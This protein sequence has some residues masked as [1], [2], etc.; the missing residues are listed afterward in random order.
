MHARTVLLSSVGPL[1]ANLYRLQTGQFSDVEEARA[2]I[3][4]LQP[5]VGDASGTE[6]EDLKVVR[7]LIDQGQLDMAR[8]ALRF[9]VSGLQKGRDIE[10]CRLLEVVVGPE[11]TIQILRQPPPGLPDSSAWGRLPLLFEPLTESGSAYP[12]AP[13]RCLIGLGAPNEI[14]IVLEADR[15]SVQKSLLHPVRIIWREK[16]RYWMED[17]GSP[18]GTWVRG[19]QLRPGESVALEHKDEVVFGNARVRI[20]LPQDHVLESNRGQIAEQTSIASLI[21]LLRSLRFGALVTDL[22]S[23]LRDSTD[24]EDQL[25]AIRREMPEAG[26]LSE[27]LC[28]LVLL[29]EFRKMKTEFLPETSDCH[30]LEVFSSITQAV[31]KAKTDAEVLDI[32]SWSERPQ[33]ITDILFPVRK[34]LKGERPASEVPIPFGLRQTLIRLTQEPV[35]RMSNDGHQ[36]L[37]EIGLDEEDLAGRP[38][39]Q[40]GVSSE[41]R[42]V[43]EEFRGVAEERLNLGVL[44]SK[45]VERAEETD[46]AF[47]FPPSMGKTEAAFYERYKEKRPTDSQEGLLSGRWSQRFLLDLFGS[48]LEGTPD[49]HWIYAGDYPQDRFEGRIYLSLRRGHALEIWSHLQRVLYPELHAR[50]IGIQYK[51]AATRENFRRSD[52]GVIYF[53]AKDQEA[54]YREVLRMRRVYPDFFKEGHP[55][56]TMPLADPDG[57]PLVGI[58]FGEHPLQRSQSFGGLRAL[59]LRNGVR[60]A[61]LLIEKGKVPGWEELCQLFAFSLDRAGIDISNPAFNQGGVDRFSFLRSRMSN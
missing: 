14:S 12:L 36:V 32:L 8:S 16:G 40:I 10:R 19:I 20:R 48:G 46:D 51:I 7:E 9:V 27:R 6:A 34:F 21:H 24:T 29:E 42:R 56:F 53:Y 15:H 52:S 18:G 17:L 60:I 61:R 23:L 43:L 57:A 50:E 35:Q 13:G 22:E 39:Q 58:S 37:Q 38:W 2:L 3:R 41:L 1:Q 26:G 11:A 45:I 54:I 59:A 47:A 33:W 30:A 28:D 49:G 31:G 5:V 44:E 4:Q 25:L 55:L